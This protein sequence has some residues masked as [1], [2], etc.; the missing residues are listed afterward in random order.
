MDWFENIFLA[1]TQWL[2]NYHRSLWSH[3]TVTVTSPYGQIVTN[4]HGP[5]CA[6]FTDGSRDVTEP[7]EVTCDSSLWPR[8]PI[9]LWPESRIILIMWPELNCVLV[10]VTRSRPIHVMD[11]YQRGS[12]FH[13]HVSPIRNTEL[14]NAGPS[15]IRWLLSVISSAPNKP[16]TWIV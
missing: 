6:V 15:A 7:P 12:Q 14:Y 1:N 10:I 11:G 9:C 2:S 5:N 4:I 8:R 13:L 3:H 16:L